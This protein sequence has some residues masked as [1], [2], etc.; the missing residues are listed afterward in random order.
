MKKKIVLIGSEGLVGKSFQKLYCEKYHILTVDK[1]N[2]I[3][4]I[5]NSNDIDTI[6]FLAQSEDYK[7][8]ELTENLFQVN[9]ELLFKTLT[10]FKNKN[11][12]FIHF[13]TG[14]VYKNNQLELKT[15]SPLDYTSTNPYVLSKIMG[16]KCIQ[17]FSNLYKSIDIMRPFFI[18]GPSQNSQMLFSV[19]IDKLK[20]NEPIKL[21]GEKG[22]IFNPIYSDDVS[23]M[24]NTLIHSNE[25]YNKIKFHNAAGKN[26]NTL[27]EMLT[28][29]AS[30]L[31][32]TANI[33]ITGSQDTQLIAKVD[34]SLFNIETNLEEG[35][36]KTILNE[37]R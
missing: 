30:I 34:T 1:Y 28:L 11:T 23:K 8:L 19:M 3:T 32:V 13:S 29:S 18:Y 4:E 27:Y 14:S 21:S 37:Y 20:K 22:L 6:V 10:M 25:S 35:L 24:I 33:E 26:I 5:D 16:E 9:V 7:N 15:D 17:S 36:R 12:K 31:G 2:S